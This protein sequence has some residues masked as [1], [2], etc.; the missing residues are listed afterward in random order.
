MNGFEIKIPHVGQKLIEKF[1]VFLVGGTIRD[2]F[3]GRKVNDY[4]LVVS[5]V[6]SFLKDFRSENPGITIFP[7]SEEDKEYRCVLRE[8]IWIDVTEFKGDT[9]EEDLRKRDF[10]INAIAYD[11]KNKMIIDPLGG[12]E[13]LR[14][15]II[16]MTSPESFIID[17]LRMLRAYR[18]SSVLSFE[19]ESLTESYIRELSPLLSIKY[20]A[21]ERIKYELFLILQSG[22]A[23]KVLS[24]M[25]ESGLL[26]SIFPELRDMKFTSQRYYN[27]QN[28][29]FHTFEA[30]KNLESIV[31]DKD[32]DEETRPILLLAM[33]LH[34]IGKPR[35][36]CYDEEG[37]THFYGHDKL[38]SEMIEEI[39][40][41]MKLSKREKNYLKKLVRFHMYPHLLAAQKVLTER[42]I[43]RYLRKME[44]LSFPLL[45]MALA[46]AL[47]SPPRG[48]GILPYDRFRE[49][50][51]KVLE[52]KQKIGK[53][54]LVTGY[55]L[56]A[57]G[58]K[59]GP[60]F[61]EILQ[62]IDDLVAEGRVRNRQDALDYILKKYVSSD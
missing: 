36:I 37:N 6:N 49:K 46:D 35:T 45:D 11:L 56:I 62:E 38:G 31:K 7:L 42:A 18:F 33:L 20:V 15:N 55:D 16:K 19:I 52:E 48:E 41:R 26:F 5:N 58:L 23:G 54:R 17:P 53:E 8:G 30:V 34:D 44:E 51:N 43:N 61:K 27:D 10:T 29:L 59:P 3:L 24:C 13:D 12:I 14:R 47:A 39:S 21:A 9:I 50:V 32:Y 40:E 25:A 2:Y 4:D 22:N 60:I 1:N 28:L 57:M